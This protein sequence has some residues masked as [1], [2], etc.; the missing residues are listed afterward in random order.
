MDYIHRHSVSGTTNPGRNP[1]R[2]ILT[3][4]KN[5]TGLDIDPA[6]INSIDD[7][8]NRIN[9]ETGFVAFNINGKLSIFSQIY[10]NK[11]ITLDESGLIELTSLELTQDGKSAF[12]IH[13]ID[14]GE[15][16]NAVYNSSDK[17]IEIFYPE[18]NK[19]SSFVFDDVTFRAAQDKIKDKGKKFIG[20][21]SQVINA[22]NSVE[23]TT[24]L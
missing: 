10:D 2:S 18:E 22:S 11:R 21:L 23:F 5:K 20:F 8:A 16:F 14:T 7:I 6:S 1:F 15:T 17:T 13:N 9:S 24:A 3:T 19:Q 4:V 12:V